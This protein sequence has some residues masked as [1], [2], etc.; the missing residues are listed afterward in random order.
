M[1]V[2]TA[3]GEEEEEVDGKQRFPLCR[4]ASCR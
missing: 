3:V 2:A 1:A 4:I